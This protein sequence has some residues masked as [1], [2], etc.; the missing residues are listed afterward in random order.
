[1]IPDTQVNPGNPE[2]DSS[3]RVLASDETNPNRQEAERLLVKRR[4]AR[5]VLVAEQPGT[6]E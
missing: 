1:M 6:R 5:E 3:L 4:I 2:H